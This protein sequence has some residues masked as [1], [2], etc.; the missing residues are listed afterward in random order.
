MGVQR[1]KA[2]VA[3]QHQ[4]ARSS[5][6]RR[7]IA[8]VTAVALGLL[9]GGAMVIA[10]PQAALAEAPVR[11]FDVIT[12]VDTVDGDPLVEGSLRWAFESIADASATDAV[13]TTYAVVLGSE[14][15]SIELVDSLTLELGEH[16]AGFSLTGASPEASVLDLSDEAMFIQSAAGLGAF[17]LSELTLQNG[18]WVSFRETQAASSALTHVTLNDLQSVSLGGLMSDT[19][20]GMQATNSQIRFESGGGDPAPEAGQYVLEVNDSSFTNAPVAITTEGLGDHSL[21]VSQVSM[22]GAQES[23]ALSVMRGSPGSVGLTVADSKL[24]DNEAGAILAERLPHTE[25]TDTT[26][27]GTGG[28]SAVAVSA[29]EGARSSLA[30]DGST[31]SGNS[32]EY[33]A[34]TI[35][36]SLADF[37]VADTVFEKNSASA[38]AGAIWANQNASSEYVDPTF[39]IT[40]SRFTGNSS[41]AQGAGAVSAP[42]WLE[43]ATGAVLEVDRTTF[44]QNSAAFGGAD[45]ALNSIQGGDE[46][47]RLVVTN[48]TFADSMSGDMASPR[49]ISALDLVGSEIALENST[50]DGV[51]GQQPFVSVGHVGETS[52]IR[53]TNDTF[54]GGGLRLEQVLPAE[55]PSGEAA[56][57]VNATVFDTSVDP[58]TIGVGATSVE[59]KHTWT[60]TASPLLGEAASASTAEFA[61]GVLAD[62]GGQTPTRLPAVNSVLIDAA[63]TT[64]ALPFDQRG[65]SRPQGKA[66]DVGS[67]ERVVGVVA[68]IEDITVLEGDDAVVPVLRDI[69][70]GVAL[71]SGAS[72]VLTARDGTA[73]AGV[74]YTFAD[75]TVAFVSGEDDKAGTQRGE[76]R[77]PTL[78]RKGIQGERDFAVE[79]GSVAEDD[80]VGETDRITVTILDRDEGTTEGNT[81]GSTDGVTEGTPEEIP[82]GGTKVPDA[83]TN[84]LAST[85]STG[86]PWGAVLGALGMLVGGAM[87]IAR[88]ATRETGTL[89]YTR[90]R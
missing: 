51:D 29:D 26:V 54:V 78:P 87:L 88:R 45:I 57:S 61:L 50:F 72:A 73:V 60:R 55:L 32:T 24:L 81:E 14:I 20:T 18:S 58:L 10:L 19:V 64:A 63:G 75:G 74:D 27:L 11:T 76:L 4:G 69:T 39:Q 82:D 43:S 62:N 30:I 83:G 85:G 68:L 49:S 5:R 38:G 25:I 12:N 67:V 65:V 15:G 23:P 56:I 34:L 42:A 21:S 80:V 46:I 3:R 86:W 90:R 7:A 53:V 35:T 79:I 66:A 22:I 31:F 36:G 2:R 47:S 8:E 70:G 33:G 28:P 41:I 17:G 77:V 48:S 52:K 13:A 16:A 84:K 71:D 89:E 37:T 40:G 6:A 44:E 1:S 59:Q 9:G